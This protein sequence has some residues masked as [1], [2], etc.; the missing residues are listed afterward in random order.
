MSKGTCLSPLLLWQI[1]KV[2]LAL[3]L[4]KI[5]Q[6]PAICRA[7]AHHHQSSSW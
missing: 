5:D 7:S 4:G 6:G 2:F 1:F 3:T